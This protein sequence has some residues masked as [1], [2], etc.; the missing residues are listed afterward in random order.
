MAKKKKKKKQKKQKK[1]TIRIYYKNG[2]NDEI[3]QKLWDGYDYIVK[4]NITTFV[5]K[6]GEQWRYMFN[7][8]SIDCILID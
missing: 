1:Q 2:C 6:K 7:M 5:V 3:P 8:D 4:D